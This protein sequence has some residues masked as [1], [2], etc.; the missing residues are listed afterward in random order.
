MCYTFGDTYTTIT[1]MTRA[2]HKITRPYGRRPSK[3]TM[4]YLIV[5]SYPPSRRRTHLPTHMH[6]SLGQHSRSK[7]R[8]PASSDES[9]TLTLPTHENHIMLY[10]THDTNNRRA[11]SLSLT[12]NTV[13]KRRSFTG[14]SARTRDATNGSHGSKK[15][16]SRLTVDRQAKPWP[17]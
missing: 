4:V 2:S 1:S 6:R 3:S 14:H 8:H 16:C 7:A 12:I 9:R 13:Q 17:Q 15:I 5:L 10:S 11:K